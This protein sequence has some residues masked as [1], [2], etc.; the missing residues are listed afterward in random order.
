MKQSS[1]STFLSIGVMSGD[2]TDEHFNRITVQRSL[3]YVFSIYI[4][5][6]IVKLLRKT[7]TEWM[8]KT[9]LLV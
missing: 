5:I 8:E 9:Q 6:R 2:E 4:R 1:T 3:E 7:E